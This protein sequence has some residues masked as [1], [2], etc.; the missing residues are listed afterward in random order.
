MILAACVLGLVFGL[1]RKGR[2]KS[3]LRK[4]FRFPALLFI[5]LAC[6]VLW[7]A[8]FVDSLLAES[9]QTARL[10]LAIL[11]AGF[12]SAFLIFNRRKPGMLFLLAGTMANSLVIIANRGRMPV[13]PF[14]ERFGSGAL[15]KIAAAP[16][17]FLAQGGEPL[18]ILSDIFP[19]WTF[20]YYMVSIGDF[21]ISIGIFL[22]A[23][24]MSKPVLRSKRISDLN[25]G[26]GMRQL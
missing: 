20:G 19:F 11:Q 16:N 8:A 7:G 14:V 25:Q 6:N 3:I 18:L 13:G 15:E 4:R 24:Y 2:L 17:Y 22:L 26:G 10:V 9:G 1:I 12:V 23:A 5:G 21:I